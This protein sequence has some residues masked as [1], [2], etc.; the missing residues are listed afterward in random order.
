MRIDGV[1]DHQELIYAVFVIR[2]DSTIYI[3]KSRRCCCLVCLTSLFL[4]EVGPRIYLTDARKR[5]SPHVEGG[6]PFAVWA[7]AI[8]ATVG[9]AT[10][11]FAGYGT[12]E[13]EPP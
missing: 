9:L 13:Q 10:F 11:A 8:H 4:G 12:L 1:C 7:Y 2:I 5:V 6:R 3:P